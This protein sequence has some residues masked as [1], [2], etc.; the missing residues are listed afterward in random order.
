MLIDVP[1][2]TIA[3]EKCASAPYKV[4]IPRLLK[5]ASRAFKL[6]Q[7]SMKVHPTKLESRCYWK[8]HLELSNGNPNKRSSTSST[9]KSNILTV[10]SNSDLLKR[11]SL[12]LQRINKTKQFFKDLLKRLE[13]LTVSFYCRTKL[14]QNFCGRPHARCK[15]SY[16]LTPPQHSYVKASACKEWHSSPVAKTSAVQPKPKINALDLKENRSGRNPRY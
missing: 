5:T 8:Q 9:Q 13:T 2:R 15:N 14:M 10:Q 3:V 11:K 1:W 12:Q 6:L 4:G 7:K 16:A